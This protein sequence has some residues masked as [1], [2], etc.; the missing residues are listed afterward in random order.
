MSNLCG[1]RMWD[2]MDILNKLTAKNSGFKCSPVIKFKSFRLGLT[3]TAA[4]VIWTARHGEEPLKE[5]LNIF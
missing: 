3:P 2:E 1:I 5:L 4:A